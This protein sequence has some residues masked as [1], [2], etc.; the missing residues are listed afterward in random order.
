MS[1]LPS[2]ALSMRTWATRLPPAS[3]TA[4][5]MGWPISSAFFSAAAM[6]RFASARVTIIVLLKASFE[7]VE[8][9]GD[10]CCVVRG[11]AQI[12]HD[13]VFVDGMWILDPVDEVCRP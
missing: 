3:T 5:F 11:H 10:V 1:M 2:Q 6:I 4:M 7:R 9:G 13:R 12:R 8:I